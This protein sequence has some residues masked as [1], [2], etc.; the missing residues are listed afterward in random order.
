M[1]S[2]SWSEESAF[3]VVHKAVPTHVLPT[4]FAPRKTIRVPHLG[5]ETAPGQKE[6]QKHASKYEHKNGDPKRGAGPVTNTQVGRPLAHNQG[7]LLS[8]DKSAG[9]MMFQRKG[10]IFRRP[11][12]SV[13]SISPDGGAVMHVH[14]GQWKKK[15][16]AIAAGAGTAAVGG[17]GAAAYKINKADKRLFKLYKYGEAAGKRD[18]VPSKF[19]DALQRRHLARVKQST[20]QPRSNLIEHAEERGY[21]NLE[22]GDAFPVNTLKRN[23]PKDDPFGKSYTKLAPKLAA[24]RNHP[25]ATDNF[26][27]RMKVNY[28]QFRR[29]AGAQRGRVNQEMKNSERYKTNPG[30][31]GWEAIDRH[32]VGESARQAAEGKAKGKLYKDAARASL[33]GYHNNHKIY[34]RILP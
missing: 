1:S 13:A 3:G 5:D 32:Q 25:E 24:V 10:T 15:N 29:T 33:T 27:Q 22:G 2:T 4:P 30:G 21:T 19:R 7:Y 18:G 6:W 34:P 16:V 20:G 9:Y 26:A 23:T 31:K 28:A 11:E 17:A 8:D 12:R 14:G